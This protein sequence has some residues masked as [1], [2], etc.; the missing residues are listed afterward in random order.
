MSGNALTNDLKA[1]IA[2]G[3]VVV[4]AGTGVSITACQ[5]QEVDGHRVARWDGLLFHGIDHCEKT[6]GLL[7]EQ[8]AEVLRMQVK[9]G[10]P[11]FLVTAAEVVS[12]RLCNRSLGVFHRWLKD[13]VGKLEPVQPEILNVL[14]SLPGVLATLAYDGLFERTTSRDP[15]TWQDRDKV[16]SVLRGEITDALLHLHGYYEQPDSVVL[17]LGSYAKVA[18]DLH[19]RAV[20]RL[21][22]LDR[23]L[24]FVGCGGTLKDPNFSRLVE[25]GSESLKDS[26]HR[27]FLLCRDEEVNALRADLKSTPWLHP[28][29]YGKGF[30]E[31]VPFL[32]GL[33]PPPGTVLRPTPKSAPV[34]PG[35]DLD[36]YRRAMRKFYGRIKLEDLDPTSHEIRPLALTG[37]FIPQ[38]ARE[39]AEFLPRA[40]ELPKELE[41]RLRESREWDV[42]ALD[43]EMFEVYGRAYR[44]ESPRPILEV[45]RDLAC[46][47]LVILGA[48]GSGK[49]TLLQYLLLQWAEQ[50]PAHPSGQALPILIDL[51]EYARLS[52]ATKVSGFLDFVDAGESVRHHLDRNRLDASLKS[53][54]SLLLFDGSRT[55]SSI[56]TNA[57][58]SQRPSNV[59]P[60]NTRVPASSSPRG[61]SVTGMRPGATKASVTLCYKTLMKRRSEISSVAGIGTPTPTARTARRNRH[62]L[63]APSRIPRQS[64][65]SPGTRCSSQ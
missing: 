2:S 64:A 52:Q 48:P 7:Q 58:K 6:H 40:F 50:T 23:T 22:T 63:P 42:S 34:A 30:D 51:R 65:S 28:V 5:D 26:T 15:I 18:E 8:E 41:Q 60:T 27:H 56:P 14:A 31:L 29:G 53:D 43:E 32:R 57:G 45:V 24:L 61:S 44:D 36:G 25:W 39:C 33:V 16:E 11:D 55:R 47:R 3:P 62:A 54:P 38:D 35:L 46:D 17:G 13:T 1:E 12:T 21:F 20:L 19:T 59:S 9:L 49:S 4:I 10:T 37:M